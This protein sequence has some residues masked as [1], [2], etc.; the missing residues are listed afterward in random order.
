MFDMVGAAVLSM[1]AWVMQKFDTR[2]GEAVRV[3]LER[4][5]E[6]AVTAHI[7]HVWD[8]S[9]P[10]VAVELRDHRQRRLGSIDCPAIPTA[11]VEALLRRHFTE[12]GRSDDA[13]DET[14][15]VFAVAEFHMPPPTPQP[16]VEP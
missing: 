3:L 12:V 7:Q 15:A 1:G 9:F 2:R 14:H 6:M 4:F 8:G 10:M 16:A 5:G 11:Y 13:S